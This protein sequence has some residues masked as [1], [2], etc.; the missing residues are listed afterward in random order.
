MDSAL[1][2]GQGSQYPHMGKSFTDEDS[3]LNFVYEAGSDILGWDLKKICL[4]TDDT[5]VLGKTVHS[6]PAIMATSIIALEAAKKR[7]FEYSAVAGHSLG[8]YASMYA[9]GMVSL[10]DVFKLIKLR[11]EAMEKAAET[12]HGTM[13][14]VL[15]ISPEKVEKVCAETD[16]YVIAANYNS[17][18]QTVIS[19]EEEAVKK[20]VEKFTELKARA[21]PLAVASAF[22][23]KIMQPAAD[24]FSE[25]IKALGVKF[26]TPKVKVYSNVLGKELDDFSESNIEDL[27]TRHIVSP[28]RFTSELNEMKN[29]GCDKFV[30]FGPG[31]VLTGLV[32]KT[33]SDVSAFKVE[34]TEDLAEALK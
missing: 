18:I 25:K 21:V 14:A 23:S 24:E 19:G 5:A 22:H 34:N 16:G 3:S 30:E 33:L 17:P 4:D 6:Q 26:N 10:E 8:E 1:F 29:S 31:R 20:A 13:A 15:K 11:S 12:S 7:G 2:S 28:V 27:L 32:K 9:A